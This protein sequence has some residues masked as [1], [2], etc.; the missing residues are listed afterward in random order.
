MERVALSEADEMLSELGGGAPTAIT[1][2]GEKLTDDLVVPDILAHLV[3]RVDDAQTPTS[4]DTS[5]PDA[6]YIVGSTGVVKA[7]QYVLGDN[8]DFR[9]GSVPSPS[10]AVSN[11]MDRPDSSQS[12]EG[13]LQKGKA[14]KLAVSLLWSARRIRGRIQT[15][16]VKQ[17][18]TDDEMVTKKLAYLDQTLR[19]IIEQFEEEYPETRIIASSEATSGEI[20]PGLPKSHDRHKTGSEDDDDSSP[21]RSPSGR[22]DN[23]VS[24]AS[25]ALSLEE[26]NILRIGQEVRRKIVDS[27]S[28]EHLP[29][30]NADATGA[31]PTLAEEQQTHER[32]LSL[33]KKFDAMSGDELKTLVENGG[34]DSAMRNIGV[35]MEMLHD[36]QK[37]DP[38]SWAK[39]EESQMKARLNSFSA[40]SDR[41]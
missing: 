39:F 11:P 16:M 36:L 33:E 29:A 34:W 6:D 37:Q 8:N 7:L 32:L 13:G 23:S 25:R 5:H 27:S 17:A 41:E 35:N 20:S 1:S 4:P 40:A 38:E 18:D 14:K 2:E 28:K 26:G 10:E 21:V 15:A 12:H 22:S 3:G 31:A 19:H 24:R 9:R 30:E